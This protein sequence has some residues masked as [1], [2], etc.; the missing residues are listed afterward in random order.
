MTHSLNSLEDISFGHNNTVG[1]GYL[2]PNSRGRSSDVDIYVRDGTY[3]G[4]KVDN[5]YVDRM[6]P[7]DANMSEI[8]TPVHNERVYCFNIYPDSPDIEK[9]REVLQDIADGDAILESQDKHP[10]DKG[11]VILLIVN[12][13]RMVFRKD[14]LDEDYPRMQ[15]NN[16]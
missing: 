6:I 11:F 4:I 8:F 16:E 3:M 12:Y 14:S 10:T 5:N 15:V 7:K 9:Y 2:F 1:E 13:A